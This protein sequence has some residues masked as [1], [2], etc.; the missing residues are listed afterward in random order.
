M[1]EFWMPL[2][3]LV[4]APPRHVVNSRVFSTA[5]H[6]AKRHRA[7]FVPFLRANHAPSSPLMSEILTEQVL[8]NRGLQP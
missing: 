5:I 4:I 7:S 6:S 1:P 2:A 8:E 3:S